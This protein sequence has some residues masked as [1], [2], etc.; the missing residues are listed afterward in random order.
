MAA[1]NIASTGIVL[2]VLTK[3]NY[4][5][6]SVL[7]KNYLIGKDL[8]YNIVEGNLDSTG[9]EWKS[10][11]GQALHAI[12]LSCGHYALRQIRNFETAQEAWNHLKVFFS[13]EDLNAAD[14]HD[15]EEESLQIDMFHMAI[16]KGLWNEANE[17]IT[18][19]G[20]NIIS[21]KSLLSSKGW[22]SL[23]VAA[24]TGQYEIMK[25]LVEKAP[26]LLAEKDS[27]GYTPFALAV[28]SDYP[29]VAVQWML[30]EGGNDLLTMQINSDDDD[31]DIPVLLTAIKGYKD[32]TGFLFCMTPWMTLRYYSD[33]IFSRCIN[34][35][36]F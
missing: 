17:Y 5:D 14:Q 24:V 16:K 29:I 9:V 22:T 13:E 11:N 4:L 7:V 2:E 15:I 30:N 36:I 12:Q 21:Q 32:M 25:K 1:A 27:A 28:Q 26:W 8:W 6:W 33:K 18:R 19:H 3:D 35:E 20:E 23:H 34:A 31:G 10:R